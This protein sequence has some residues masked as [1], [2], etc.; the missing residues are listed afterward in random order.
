[1]VDGVRGRGG[2]DG[3]GQR[4]RR[5]APVGGDGRGAGVGGRRSG[6][7]D[8]LRERHER[9]QTREFAAGAAV[10]E[11]LHHPPHG[12]TRPGVVQRAEEAEVHDPSDV[13]QRGGAVVW[14]LRVRGVEQL[15]LIGQ[16]AH[17]VEHEDLV[18]GVRQVDGVCWF[19]V[20]GST[21]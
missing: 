17:P 11:V 5:R 3:I 13:E 2:V 7:G 8:V 15:P 19:V 9:R 12:W 14:Q 16:P 6:E 4:R 1:V 20:E 18:V 10:G 21:P